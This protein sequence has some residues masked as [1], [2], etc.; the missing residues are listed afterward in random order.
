MLS[1]PQFPPSMPLNPDQA[2]GLITQCLKQVTLQL[3]AASHRYH[4]SPKSITLLAVSKGQP[5]SAIREAAAAG[6]RQFGESY[7]Q[8]AL[9]KMESCRDLPLTWHYIGHIQS[10]KTRSIAEHFDW[11]HTVDRLKTAQRLNEHRP[12][13]AKP[14]QVCIQAKL[15][16]E[17]T[18]GGADPA[19]LSELAESI[20]ELPRL[21]LRGLM[22]IPPAADDVEK[23]RGYFSQLAGLQK[24]LNQKL[25]ARG[26]SLDTL[27]MGMSGDF[28]AA[29]AEGS[30]MVRIGTAIFGERK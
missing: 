15:A 11:V 2:Q 29:I 14:L 12:H 5:A 1:S 23:Q 3:D 22:C 21:Q 13:Y 26:V 17:D 6:Q 18:K 19:E 9:P 10:N 4:R 30:T 27:S 25:A 8:E 20:L 7:V 28:E 24:H 16:Q